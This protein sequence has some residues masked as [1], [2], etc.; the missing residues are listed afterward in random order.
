MMGPSVPQQQAQRQGTYS[1]AFA[2]A[3]SGS[4]QKFSHA[5][6][7]H[8]AA[9]AR[10]ITSDMAYG[11]NRSSQYMKSYSSSL[12]MPMHSDM[13]YDDVEQ[14]VQAQAQAEATAARLVAQ[15][16]AS[17]QKNSSST[18]AKDEVASAPSDNSEKRFTGRIR[19]FNVGQ[20]FGF[21]E[22]V[23]V[24]KIHGCD[25]FLN[26]AVEGGVVVGS[27]VSFALELN[28]N[29]K[30]QA[31]RV[32]LEDA[33]T[34]KT[35][36]PAKPSQELSSQ[37]RGIQ[38]QSKVKSFNTSRGFGFIA[39]PPDLQYS[40]GGRDIYLSKNQIPDGG[41]FVGQEVEFKLVVDAQGQPQA[42]DVRVVPKTRGL[43]LPYTGL[44]FS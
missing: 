14:R 36:T 32:V 23:E 37:I 11:A 28:K 17:T 9:D 18:Q 44:P 1:R 19:S 3:I 13:R 38:Y 27:T 6:A 15:N 10:G 21:I 35:S 2:D 42:R 8:K 4:L 5:E 34:A 39:T 30:P 20:G 41:I 16:A 29:G 40:F 43:N 12:S 22:S 24:A 31:R 25:V 33:S 26:Q 7:M